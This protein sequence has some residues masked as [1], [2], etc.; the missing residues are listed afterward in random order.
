[1]WFPLTHFHPIIHLLSQIPD[2]GWP[3][4][5]W[6][7]TSAHLHYNKVATR[8]TATL[9]VGSRSPYLC[10]FPYKSNYRNSALALFIGRDKNGILFVA[11]WNVQI[12]LVY[13]P[14]N[15][16]RLVYDDLVDVVGGLSAFNRGR[17][18]RVQLAWFV[19]F[20]KCLL[21]IW[22]EEIRALS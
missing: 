4:P 7:P 6:P 9:P 10:N 18:L 13:A 8:L 11:R 5:P 3:P 19:V 16:A 1:M 2:V 22:R 21:T 17:V 15:A 12:P 20:C 14:T